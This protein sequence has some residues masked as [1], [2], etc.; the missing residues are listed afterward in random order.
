MSAASGMY[1]TRP[2][3]VRDSLTLGFVGAAGWGIAP[4]AGEPRLALPSLAAGALAATSTFAAGRRRAAR[5]FLLDY[6]AQA[7]APLTGTPAENVRALVKVTGW[8]RGRAGLP[9][10]LPKTV[11]LYYGQG[12]TKTTETLGVE[13]G[14]SRW[15]SEIAKLAS[16]RFGGTYRV[17]SNNQV[18]GQLRLELV[19]NATPAAK[20]SPQVERA[21]KYV[22]RF[23]GGATTIKDVEVDP[24]TGQPIRML[25]EHDIADKLAASGYRRRVEAGVST[26]L[27]GRWRARWD[28][29]GDSV[30][31]EVRPSLPE[32]VWIE[33]LDPPAVDP[34]SNYR[35]VQIPYGVDEDGEVIAWRPAV[36]PQWLITGGTGSGKLEPLTNLIPTP[37]GFTA[38]GDLAVDDWVFGRDGKPC[39]VRRLWPIIEAPFLYKVTFSDGQ[40]ID[41]DHDHQWL[42]ST[43]QSRKTA[44]SSKRQTAIENHCAWK[45][46]I[47]VLEQIA[48]EVSSREVT[49]RELLAFVH[50]RVEGLPW[51]TQLGARAALDTVECPFRIENRLVP[52]SSGDF[53]R[54]VRLY[55]LS[56]ALKALAVRLAEQ[57]HTSP[58]G[59]AY[60]MRMTTGEMLAAG[61]TAAG[62]QTN[63]AVRVAGAVEL[64]AADLAVPP[65]VLG[66]WLGDG[67]RGSG[68]F[69]QSD[70]A[71]G[72]SASS[73]M[74]NLIS[75]LAV[76]GF[77]CRRGSDGKTIGT[78]GLHGRLREIGV[79][80]NKHIPIRYLRASAAQRLAVLQGLMDT[81][82][83]VGV[84]GCCE[85]SLSDRRLAQ[86][87]LAL[88]RS[89]GIKASVSWDQ[90]ASYR[91][92][93]TGQLIKCQDRHRIHFTTTKQ[94]FRLQRKRDRLP[95][96]VRE[97]QHWLYITSIEP[98]DSQPGRCI[99]VDSPDHTYLTGTGFVPTSNTS[100]GHGI[101]TQISRYGWPIWIADGK[102]V[103]FLGFQDWPNVQIVA[104]TIPE[105]IAVI[106][107]AW[108]VME[109]RYQLVVQ[110]K[111]RSED[112]EPLMVFVDEF[113]DLKANLTTWYSQIKVKGDPT[114]PVTLSQ[115]GSIARKGRTARVHLVLTLQRPDAEILTGEV[116]E[117]FGQRTSL[118]PISPQ[119][120]EMMWNNPVTGVAL[121]RGRTGRAIGT[122]NIGIPVEMQAYRVP[123]PADALPGT[124]EYELLER[125]RP[126]D[127]RHER[128]LIVPPEID[129]DTGEPIDPTFTDHAEAE[130]VLA[131]DRPDLD[132]LVNIENIGHG[133]VDGRALSSPLA[134]LGLVDTGGS[135]GSHRAGR[136]GMSPSSRASSTQV[137]E[138]PV[139]E[140]HGDEV[141]DG[142]DLPSTIR[143]AALVPGDRICVDADAG[144]WAV[145]EEEP[146]ADF[147]DDECLVIS[148]RD[149]EDLSGQNVIPADAFVEAR[150]PRDL[151]D[152][153]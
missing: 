58:S 31:L 16:R 2:T 136:R 71:A 127:S 35:E 79:L 114:K 134:S 132:P 133:D 145:V 49:L 137:D 77:E 70:L 61:L 50:Q 86:D 93:E 116:R 73:D 27:P 60:E 151:E 51:V 78:V 150:R 106:H 1:P 23:L 92:A 6:F 56:I 141:D 96:R 30:V 131:K 7:V 130:W 48:A 28:L 84:N 87:A 74:A 81:D 142:Y 9:K 147:D 57:H 126:A 122:N 46:R 99:T 21:T 97:T 64:P 36:S 123:D 140:P 24:E 66:A 129:W 108:Q 17:R 33:P 72:P 153:A 5:E 125:L 14:D 15:A 139:D 41:V 119:G 98:V 110:R 38:M 20:D 104:S 4:L 62:G 8:T 45:T 59:A 26:V 143:V 109:D 128:L 69:T 88:I 65:Y 34:L 39:Q 120:A 113:T 68:Q 118:G 103:E 29:E 53:A 89:L 76:A 3:Y 121:P 144:H 11:R 124:P 94:V 135:A 90:P 75:E 52:R 18:R 80:Y 115:I 112:F 152:A 101:L 95:E 102:G 32:S 47:V 42:V 43:F 146:I 149:D 12:K 55:D 40:T 107:R 13:I 44:R 54:P 85:I 117:N 100:T 10:A 83:T 67:S 91:D 63:F 25:V 19:K 82:G 138:S 105:Q 37:T 22:N 111:A 148:W